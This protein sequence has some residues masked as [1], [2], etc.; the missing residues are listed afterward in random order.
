MCKAKPKTPLPAHEAEAAN[1]VLFFATMVGFLVEKTPAC[2]FKEQ[3]RLS[4]AVKFYRWSTD[5]GDPRTAG[6]RVRNQ[7]VPFPNRSLA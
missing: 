1:N 6:S 2:Q 7:A 4:C 3:G 5:G